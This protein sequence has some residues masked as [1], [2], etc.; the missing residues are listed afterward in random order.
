MGGGGNGGPPNKWIKYSALQPMTDDQ[1]LD[2]LNTPVESSP[3]TAA[4]I[5]P[6]TGTLF[7]GYYGSGN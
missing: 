3:A 7:V 4:F 2:I 5:N 1:I 6:V